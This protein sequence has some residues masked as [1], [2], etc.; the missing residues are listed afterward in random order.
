[1]S[2]I[3]D[4]T[5]R[6]LMRGDGPSEWDVSEALRAAATDEREACAAKAREYAAHYDA[7]SDGR[8]TLIM[9]AEWIE[10][11]AMAQNK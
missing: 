1:M 11:R 8:N 2:D 7:G 10:N 5:A 9:L 4:E 6:G 3:H